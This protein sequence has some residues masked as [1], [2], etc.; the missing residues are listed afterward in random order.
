MYDEERDRMLLFGG[1]GDAALGDLWE[2][3][4]D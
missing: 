1:I 4:F 3:T 2:L